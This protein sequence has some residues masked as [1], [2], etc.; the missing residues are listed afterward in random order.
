ML[1]NGRPVTLTGKPRYVYVDVFD[2]IDFDLSN[3]K[4]SIVNKINGR[5]AKFMEPLGAGDVI[6]IYW[7]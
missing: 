4:G 6:E 3:P 1:V 5:S 2:F 7:Q